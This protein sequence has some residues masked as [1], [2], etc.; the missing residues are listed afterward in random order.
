MR[1]MFSPCSAYLGCVCVSVIFLVFLG[2]SEAVLDYLRSSFVMYDAVSLFIFSEA[3]Y[4][5]SI[6]R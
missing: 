2:I 3:S 6:G 4:F 1:P 5:Y